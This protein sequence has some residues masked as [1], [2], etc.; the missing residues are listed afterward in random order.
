[1][2]YSGITQYKI[3]ITITNVTIKLTSCGENHETPMNGSTENDNQNGYLMLL[4]V[5]MYTK[6]TRLI[7]DCL[8]I[9]DQAPQV[10]HC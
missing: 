4:I 10:G 7:D 5:L 2:N 9:Q 8:Q 1:M 3:V 6:S